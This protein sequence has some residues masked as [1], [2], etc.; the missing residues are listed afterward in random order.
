[1]DLTWF[2]TLSILNILT[3]IGYTFKYLQQKGRFK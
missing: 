2:I 3:I 1:M